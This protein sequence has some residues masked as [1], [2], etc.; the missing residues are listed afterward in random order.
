M[1]N[2]TKT[3]RRPSAARYRPDCV[4]PSTILAAIEHKIDAGELSASGF[5]RQVAGDPRLVFD[6]RK[7]RWITPRIA[8]RIRSSLQE[9]V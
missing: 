9:A 2:A 1:G 6:L 4:D 7:G 8:A 5:G 3:H